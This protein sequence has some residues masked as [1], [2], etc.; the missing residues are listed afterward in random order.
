MAEV[1][2]ELSSAWPAVLLALSIW[3]LV[4]PAGERRL[5]RPRRRRAP[6][7]LS[8]LP[9]ALGPAPRALASGALAAA[10]ALWSSALGSSALGA[11]APGW[12]ALLPAGLA[13]A[14]AFVALGRVTTAGGARRTAVLVGS[15]PQVCDLLA[16]A[17]AAGQP[18]R[19]AVEVVAPAV[20]GPAGEALAG[21]AAKVRLGESEAQAWAELEEEPAL[22]HIAREVSRTVATGLGLAPLLRELAVEARR[23]AAA[24]AV[25]R[26]RQVGV[27]SVL[28][29]MAAFLPSFLLLGVVPVVGGI[30][31]AVLP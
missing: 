29:L 30:I 6:G 18:L 14:V 31:A 23:V 9:D 21:V 7:W 19:R 28:P 17:V 16:V 20:G 2:A 3:L 22:Q 10:V 15:L 11:S 1:S 24:D 12:G 27:R 8:P 26:A 5:A 25:V 4:P 13:A